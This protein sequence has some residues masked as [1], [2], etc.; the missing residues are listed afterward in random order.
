MM[1]KDARLNGGAIDNGT[2]PNPVS[3]LFNDSIKYNITTVNANI[4]TGTITIIDTLPPYLKLDTATATTGYTI[5]AT[6]GAPSQTVLEWS[7]VLPSMATKTVQYQTTPQSGACASQ[8]LFINKAR[9]RVSDTIYVYT[10]STYHQGA[11]IAVVTFSASL[12]GSLFHA[13]EQALDYR[14]SPRAGILVVPDEGYEFAGWS[15]G[16]YTSLR[17]ETVKADSGILHYENIVI[18]GNVELRARFVPLRDKPVEKVIVEEKVTD[19]SDKVWSNNR[20]LYI[21]TKKGTMTRIY[22]TEG[23]L[24]RLFAI[25]EDGTTTVS[26]ERGIYIVTLN[27]GVGYKVIIE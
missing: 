2:Y 21:R 12:G 11:G 19:N 1:K 10:N 22:T 17:G 20:N 23:I 25:T 24:Q 8:P 16:D 27:D 14:T 18:Y 6:S 9:V 13:G 5:S 26:L 3:V 4:S 7:E 15:H